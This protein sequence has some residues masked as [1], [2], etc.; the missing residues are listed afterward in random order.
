MS[1][2]CQKIDLKVVSIVYYRC[3]CFGIFT[4]DG[5][6]MVTTLFDFAYYIIILCFIPCNEN[7]RRR[8]TVEICI[9]PNRL[10]KTCIVVQK[11]RHVWWFL[12]TIIIYIFFRR[13]YAIVYA[14]KTDQTS[15][16]DIPG[17]SYHR[18]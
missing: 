16:F 12:N 9:F 18:V 13:E 1:H 11:F 17:T 7:C 5:R 10:L 4:V 8:E 2:F 3:F 6:Y 15:F 14:L